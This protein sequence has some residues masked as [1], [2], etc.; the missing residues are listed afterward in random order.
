MSKTKAQEF[1]NFLKALKN[2]DIAYVRVVDRDNM[3]CYINDS[4]DWTYRI[5]KKDSTSPT[6]VLWTGDQFSGHENWVM[7]DVFDTLNIPTK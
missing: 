6:K 1:E 7:R 2:T 5:Y 3:N 4:K